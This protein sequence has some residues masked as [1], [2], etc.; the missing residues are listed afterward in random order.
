[1]SQTKNSQERKVIE[2]S[3]SGSIESQ[4]RDIGISA[5]A[6]AA[7]YTGKSGNLS[8]KTSK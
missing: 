4:Y 8:S 6:A 2:S 5:V 7:A 1:M 3:Q